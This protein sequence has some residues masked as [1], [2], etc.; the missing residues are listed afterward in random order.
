MEKEIRKGKSN[1]F[2]ESKRTEKK[3]DDENCEFLIPM[4]LIVMQGGPGTLQTI[5]ESLKRN[6]P[7][8]IL[9]VNIRIL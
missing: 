4:V 3:S 7:V 6:V 2:Y 5:E 8:L 1:I 9:A